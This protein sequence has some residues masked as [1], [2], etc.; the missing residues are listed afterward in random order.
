MN[1]RQEV[2]DILIEDKVNQLM[3]DRDF[4]VHV[5][6][7]GFPGL[8]TMDKDELHQMVVDA[9]LDRRE[10]MPERLA[11]LAKQRIPTTKTTKAAK[12]V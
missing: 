1:A 3:G 6:T 10:G 11:K 9:G 8:A 4:A 12:S 2:L 7:N 5:I